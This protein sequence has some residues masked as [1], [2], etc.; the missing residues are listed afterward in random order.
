MQVISVFLYKTDKTW[1]GKEESKTTGSRNSEQGNEDSA[2]P[3]SPC[4]QPRF[5]TSENVSH[6]AKRRA[7]KEFETDHWRR[8]K[9]PNVASGDGYKSLRTPSKGRDSSCALRTRLR[10]SRAAQRDRWWTALGN[11]SVQRIMQ[12]FEGQN[13]DRGR[14][15]GRKTPMQGGKCHL[16]E[17]WSRLMEPTMTSSSSERKRKAN[18]RDECE[19]QGGEE[20]VVDGV[21]GRPA[22]SVSFRPCATS[23]LK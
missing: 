11:E 14:K 9:W 6:R 17:G 16:A 1:N 3:L 8:A 23:W 10:S 12:S 5:T 7:E 20:L 13:G 2:H 19:R 21:D 4:I 22:A 15:S 18:H